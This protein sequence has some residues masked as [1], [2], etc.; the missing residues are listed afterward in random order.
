MSTPGIA[1]STL[2]TAMSTPRIAI[3]TPRIAISTREDCYVYTPLS[4]C[5]VAVASKRSRH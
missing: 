2:R 1:I 3:S 5:V 4:H